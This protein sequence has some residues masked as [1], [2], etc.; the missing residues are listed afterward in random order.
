[1]LDVP[2]IDDSVPDST[3][4][5]DSPG[6]IWVA[7][8]SLPDSVFT[9]QVE[10][11]S[12]E[13]DYQKHLSA[14]K[15]WR[16]YDCKL[17]MFS[18]DECSLCLESLHNVEKLTDRIKY[19]PLPD[20]RNYKHWECY[21]CNRFF[22]STD[23][24]ASCY[25]RNHEIEQIEKLPSV[26]PNTADNYFENHVDYDVLEDDFTQSY[27]RYIDQIKSGKWCG[28]EYPKPWL[29]PGMLIGKVSCGG[30]VTRGCMGP[31]TLIHT[32]STVK[33]TTL[34]KGKLAVVKRHM[35]MCKQH[36]CF[37]CFEYTITLQAMLVQERLEAHVVRLDSEL[38]DKRKKRIF[39]HFIVSFRR[40]MIE[41]LK[42]PKVMKKEINKID[43][44]MTKLGIEGGVRIL[45]GWRFTKNLG[46]PYW[47]PHLHFICTGYTE[48][49]DIIAK[50]KETGHV[51]HH[52]ENKDRNGITIPFIEGK[53]VFN[54]ARYLLSHSAVAYRKQSYVF[55]GEAQN[56]KFKT[57]TILNNSSSC[58]DDIDNHL[59]DIES[60]SL[61]QKKYTSCSV[62]RCDTQIFKCG[63]EFLAKQYVKENVKTYT[64]ENIIRQLAVDLKEHVEMGHKDNPAKSKSEPEG[65]EQLT[66][67]MTHSDYSFV[68]MK[69]QFQVGTISIEKC[70]DEIRYHILRLDPN[71][72]CLCPICNARMRTMI[73]KEPEKAPELSSEED[74]TMV[75]SKLW[76]YY[77]PLIHGKEG[78]PYYTDETNVFSKDIGQRDTNEFY[79]D[80]VPWV[81]TMQMD[82]IEERMPGVFRHEFLDGNTKPDYAA[83]YDY[84]AERMEYW[85]KEVR[86][87]TIDAAKVQRDAVVTKDIQDGKQEQLF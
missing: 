37:K 21:S 45:H 80:Q 67:S 9:E 81:Q 42:N 16:C 85:R 59:T 66:P 78:M 2:I 25:A 62:V 14:D 15:V 56:S 74:F 71:V 63:S 31:D 7:A 23:T 48:P 13:Q 51:F 64:G 77:S 4:E 70:E 44:H 82:M 30:W 19:S 47:S 53:G 34:H 35:M 28:I 20:P 49:E 33:Q 46:E 84:V 58:N 3:E 52:V 87:I 83:C 41:E 60:G 69:I 55:M 38:H 72:S 68:V 24:A 12:K 36:S 79:D 1:M 50:N 75:D 40:D 11:E 54:L 6:S 26:I 27:Q 61:V 76:E 29:L 22:Y 10:I 18:E 86:G 8:A 39:N 32:K 57:V 65:T 73:Q 43:K 17:F 5:I